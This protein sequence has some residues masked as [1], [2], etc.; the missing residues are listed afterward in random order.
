MLRRL[1]GVAL[2]VVSACDLDLCNAAAATLFF[3]HSWL[4]ARQLALMLGIY[5]ALHLLA[6]RFVIAL[7]WLTW[8]L[9]AACTVGL[10]TPLPHEWARCCH[11][12]CKK[13]CMGLTDTTGLHIVWRRQDNQVQ[14]MSRHTNIVP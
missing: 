12:G 13:C 11:Q 5:N 9:C 8:P 10:V 2:V 1:L 3:L 4:Q 6:C 7:L 14:K